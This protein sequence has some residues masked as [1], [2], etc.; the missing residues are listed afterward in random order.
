MSGRRRCP[1]YIVLD[2]LEEEIIIDKNLTI[3]YVNCDQEKDNK[4]CKHAVAITY[5]SFHSN[6]VV[7]DVPLYWSELANKFLKFPSHHIRVVVTGKTVNRR[8]GLG[9]ERGQLITFFMETIAL[10][11]SLKNL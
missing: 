3:F 5:D 1:L 10:S 7:G 11:N 6:E 8:I 4:H 2:F 9:L